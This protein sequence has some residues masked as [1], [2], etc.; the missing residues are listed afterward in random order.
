MS[1][2]ISFA[3]IDPGLQGALAIIRPDGAV[4]FFEPPI[5][6]VEMTTKTKAG[7][8]KHKSTYLPGEMFQILRDANIGFAT[9]ELTRPMPFR[10]AGGRVV[11]MPAVSAFSSGQGYGFWEM[12][13][14]A[15]GISYQLVTPSRWK[16][17][18][19][20]D[21]PKTKEA[22]VPAAAR[23]YPS[24]TPFLKTVRGRAID[25]RADALL[26]AHYGRAGLG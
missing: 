4:E 21:Q 14:V 3:G 22:S 10:G 11:Q 15:L 23:L 1:D 19:M 25:G 12:A 17:A 18:L 13:L 5:V 7:N 20:Q 24:A 9:M 2:N 8:K 6:S 26:L 16:A